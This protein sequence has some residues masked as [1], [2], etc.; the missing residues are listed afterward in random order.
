M[1]LNQVMMLSLIYIVCMKICMQRLYKAALRQ[2]RATPNRT[3]LEYMRLVY[4]MLCRHVFT[5]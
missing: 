1:V 3:M 2:I 5:F 4:S